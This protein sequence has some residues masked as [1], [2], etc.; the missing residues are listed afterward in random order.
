MAE[1]ESNPLVRQVEPGLCVFIHLF[2]TA[3]T[4]IHSQMRVHFGDDE[5]PRIIDGDSFFDEIEHAVTDGHA[6]AIAGHYSFMRMGAALERIGIDKKGVTYFSFV[7]DPI[8][9][10]VSAY[11]YFRSNDEEKWHLEALS[12]P[13]LEFFE[14]AVVNDPQMVV[15]HQCLYLS[16]HS[17]PTFSAAKSNIET[18]FAFVGATERIADIATISER[19]I[20]FS[21]D[22]SI[23]RNQADR[24][25]GIEDLDKNTLDLLD[26]ITAE[27]RKLHQY[28]LD[29]GVQQ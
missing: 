12:L 26:S 19:K 23:K 13:A 20:G 24:S 6:K 4:S 25:V 27:D 3:G 21:F 14:F 10:L 28:I 29:L 11:N 22:P 1:S 17:E 8:E 2:K 18:N 16:E 9:R 15:N 7:R 5:V